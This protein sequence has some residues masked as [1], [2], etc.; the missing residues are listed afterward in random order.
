MYKK[1]VIVSQ[2]PTASL[3]LKKCVLAF[4]LHT[5]DTQEVSSNCSLFSRSAVFLKEK[6]IKF[7]FHSYGTLNLFIYF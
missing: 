4:Q 3:F 5:H 2:H 1:C 7:D 6:K